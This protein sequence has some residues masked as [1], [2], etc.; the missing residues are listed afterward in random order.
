MS[1]KLQLA[2]IAT[3][4]QTKRRQVVG[5]VLIAVLIVGLLY[6]CWWVFTHEDSRRFRG[7]E[8]FRSEI[9]IPVR[10]MALKLGTRRPTGSLWEARSSP[11]SS[12]CLGPPAKLGTYIILVK[13][14]LHA[15]VH[16]RP[17]R[18]ANQSYEGG[19]IL[20][21]VCFR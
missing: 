11:E 8:K 13:E 6:V 18:L 4:R 20:G 12:N 19:E 16:L 7:I 14:D 9:E 5:Y 1:R 17:S 15:L 10:E 3:E 2:L 21:G